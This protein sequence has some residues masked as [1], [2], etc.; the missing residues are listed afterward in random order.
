MAVVGEELP[1]VYLKRRPIGERFTN[2]N[3]SVEIGLADELFSTDEQAGILA[4]CRSMALELGELDVL[5]DARTGHIYIVDVNSMPFGPPKPIAHHDALR[6]IAL[7]A[8]AFNRLAERW[9]VA[10]AQRT[11]SR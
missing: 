1:L 10:D 2:R 6:A 8:D 4:F 3:S 7:Y 9:L 11:A 5:R